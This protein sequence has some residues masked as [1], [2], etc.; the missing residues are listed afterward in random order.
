MTHRF[1]EKGENRNEGVFE[2]PKYEEVETGA[3]TFRI[4]TS[5]VLQTNSLNSNGSS[6]SI[7]STRSFILDLNCST[8]PATPKFA[9]Q[10]SN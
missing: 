4:F 5:Y 1:R 6:L 9:R 7:N 10:A 8:F 2:R 3:G